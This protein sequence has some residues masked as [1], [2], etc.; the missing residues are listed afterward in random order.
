MK[1]LIT[2]VLLSATIISCKKEKEETIDFNGRW[3]MISDTS[4]YIDVMRINDSMVDITFPKKIDTPPK[5]QGAITLSY[6]IRVSNDTTFCVSGNI[7]PGCYF[8]NKKT[9]Y[10][11]YIA[12]WT[13]GPELGAIKELI[14]E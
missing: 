10:K 2:I 13:Q 8:V 12:E 6:S 9:F 5:Y 7:Y 4:R 11:G 1:K 14:N 3:S